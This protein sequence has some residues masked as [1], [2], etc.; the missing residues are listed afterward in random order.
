MHMN[1]KLPFDL[2]RV[3]GFRPKPK[4]PAT[5]KYASFNRRMLAATIDMT[6]ISLLVAPLV[7]YAFNYFYPPIAV[8]WPI[9]SGQMTETDQ[10]RVMADFLKSLSESGY[11]DRWLINSQIQIIVLL[12]YSG[13]CWLRW[14]STPGKMLL[15]MKIVD[16]KT[17]AP[18]TIL[19]M[20]MRLAGYF[21]SGLMLGIGF[22]WIGVDKRRQGWHDKLAETVVILLPKKNA[23]AIPDSPAADPSDSPAPSA[24]E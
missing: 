8:T 23:G 17:E 16:A 7:D 20:L 14:S 18:M 22:F 19:Q 5:L 6:L 10:Q 3:A 24:G 15:R 2:F 1:T 21:M 4:D 13:L 11:I 9:F 12:L